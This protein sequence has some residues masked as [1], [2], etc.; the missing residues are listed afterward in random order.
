M[1]PRVRM[2]LELTS[3][4]IHPDSLETTVDSTLMSVPVS[5]VSMEVCVWT[6]EAILTVTAQVVDSQGCIVRQYEKVT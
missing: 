3:V 5:P 6:E 2:L 1:V 4:T